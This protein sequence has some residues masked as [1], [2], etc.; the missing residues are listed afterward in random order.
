[1]TARSRLAAAALFVALALASAEARGQAAPAA[2]PAPR[3]P[4]APRAAAG[5]ER[6]DR[7]SIALLA[8]DARSRAARRGGVSELIVD[9]EGALV[10]VVPPGRTGR[11]RVGSVA[12]L[13]V[14]ALPPGGL[15][16][17][18]ARE[19]ARGLAGSLGAGP[20]ELEVALATVRQSLA[21]AGVTGA[22]IVLIEREL[23]HDRRAR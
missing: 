7:L 5:A 20:S 13:L 9:L 19:L 11:G 1:M 12:R 15:D 8:V 23:A 21:A 16:P 14:G 2:P 22:D 10:E 18:R 4:S 6:L 3:A 17:G